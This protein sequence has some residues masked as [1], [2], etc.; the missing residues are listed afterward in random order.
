MMSIKS[1]ILSQVKGL[2]S[3]RR[4]VI[5]VTYIDLLLIEPLGSKFIEIWM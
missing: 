2:S 4:Q 5:A 1:L 3:V